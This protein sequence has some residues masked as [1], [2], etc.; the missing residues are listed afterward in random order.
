[1]GSVSFYDKE[2]IELIIK[3]LRDLQEKSIKD[4]ETFKWCKNHS[5]N[6]PTTFNCIIE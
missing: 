2:D 5:I 3:A 6:K 4:N 1:M